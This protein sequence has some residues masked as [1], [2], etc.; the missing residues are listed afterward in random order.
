MAVE[1]GVDRVML[2]DDDFT[3]NF[4]AK[5]ILEVSGFA[6]SVVE[7][8]SCTSAIT[9]LQQNTAQLPDIIF[10]DLNMP[11]CDGFDFLEKF[12][13]LN[14]QITTKCKVIILSSSDNKKDIERILTNDHV[15][16]FITKPITEEALEEIHL[17]NA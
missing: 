5:R 4:I 10:L 14:P 15:I 9:Y 17:K 6:K 11:L 2:V 1:N 7:M 12:E 13:K 8:N 3:D 16:K